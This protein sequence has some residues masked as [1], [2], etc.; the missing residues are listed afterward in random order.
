MLH[1]QCLNLPSNIPYYVT[2]LIFISCFIILL[3]AEDVIQIFRDLARVPN[4]SSGRIGNLLE[5]GHIQIHTTWTQRDLERSENITFVKDYLVQLDVVIP[6][7]PV[8]ISNVYV[9]ASD[10]L[11][12]L[13]E[14]CRK[15][16]LN[17][18]Q[19]HLK[20]SIQFAGGF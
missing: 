17:H 5:P 14:C 20:Y 13:L 18:V 11:C 3:Q 7:P 1:V 9:G 6:T 4:I 15:I 8:E 19:F 16:V 10:L 2:I 12:L